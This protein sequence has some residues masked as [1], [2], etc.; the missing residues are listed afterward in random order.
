MVIRVARFNIYLLALVVLVSA[1][2]CRTAE[3]RRNKQ[4]AVLRVHLEVS[5]DPTGLGELVSVIRAS[6]MVLH[7]AKSAFLTESEVAKARVIETRGGFALQIQF[8][9]R[10]TILL[11][12]VTA[13]NPG[14]RMV[15][16]AQFGEKLENWRWLAAPVINR[17]IADGVLTFTPDADREEATEIEL[18]LNNLAAKT[19]PGAKEKK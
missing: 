14:K 1:T 2:G 16:K 15:I 11:E 3:S 8:D 5:R 12:Q 4:V 6:P 13:T 18:G 19:Q 17:R 9:A 7:V 10:G